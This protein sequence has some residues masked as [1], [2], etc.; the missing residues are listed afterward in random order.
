MRKILILTVLLI[1]L[2]FPRMEV[3]AW[4][5]DELD[6]W[7]KQYC[8]ENGLNPDD[9]RGSGGTRDDLYIGNTQQQTTPTPEATTPAPTIAPTPT[10]T[11]KHEH[12]YTAD[13]TTDPK[14]TEGGIITYTCECG[15]TYTEPMEPIGHQY[16]A[17]VSKEATC[18]TDGEKAFTCS[19]CDDTYTEAVPATGHEIGTSLIT[20]DANCTEDGIRETYCKNCGEVLETESLPALGHTEGEWNIEIEA[21]MTK[22]GENVLRC[23]TCN[24]VLQTEVLPI[25]MTGWY[26]VGGIAAVLAIVIAVVVIVTKKKRMQGSFLCIQPMCSGVGGKTVKKEKEQKR[27]LH[28]RCNYQTINYTMD[29]I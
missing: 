4:T 14:C 8:E 7:F 21:T 3:N 17:E 24:E 28:H 23:T 5:Q 11:P 16:E 6:E 2:T 12:K 26:Y 19:L 1:G 18:D 22:Q 15:D 25:N 13:L 20:K 9:Y 10:P 29:V 27:L